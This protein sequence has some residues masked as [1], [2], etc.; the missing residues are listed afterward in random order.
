MILG[1]FGTL[2]ATVQWIKQNGNN[3]E[4]NEQPYVNLVTVAEGTLVGLYYIIIRIYILYN[5]SIS[6][7][8]YLFLIRTPQTI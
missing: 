7:F 6:L 1:L 5:R 8:K 2:C 3:T 4:Q